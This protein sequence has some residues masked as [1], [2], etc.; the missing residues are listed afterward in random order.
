MERGAKRATGARA[1]A[2]GAAYPGGIPGLLAGAVVTAA[3]GHAWAGPE[4]EQVVQGQATFQRQ[5]DLT[6]IH[7][8]NNAVIN[9]RSFDIGA[10]EKVQFVQPDALSRVLNRINSAVPTRIDGT[11]TANGRVYIV[12]PAGVMF[13][14]GA[15]ID[16]ARLF[17]A[18]G[19][20]ADAD[21]LKNAD[22]FTDLRGAARCT[23]PR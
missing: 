10:N 21:F 13:G 8:G 7:A 17:A 11:L 2:R 6:V 5:G 15:V 16:V 22:R 9:Y 3:A 18:G 1:A 23:P 4:G 14:K 19:N 12:N 20:L